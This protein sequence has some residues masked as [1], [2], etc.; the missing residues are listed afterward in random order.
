MSSSKL[1]II[2]APSGAGKT[3]IVQHIIKKFPHLNFSVSATTREARPGEE[4][5]QD[6]YFLSVNEFLK[7]VDSKDFIEWEQV[8]PGKYY[9]TLRS[10]V[11][12]RLNDG[13]SL[14][15]DIDVRG[16]MSLKNQF[17]DNSLTI[18]I[19]TPNLQTLVNR[20][21][22]R[23]TESP[24]ELKNRIEK[25]KKE[26]LYEHNFDSIIVNDILKDTFKKVEELVNSFLKD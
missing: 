7:K 14:I 13:Q 2:T 12:K 23:K 22:K 3:T 24:E 9:G 15:F 18:F 6:Y 19:K 20:L 1:L 8:Y 21:I 5:G 16:A 25:A 4:D 26:L 10:E 17:P 11:E